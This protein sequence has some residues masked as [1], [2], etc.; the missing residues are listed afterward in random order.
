VTGEPSRGVLTAEEA[1]A[2]ASAL[3]S[4]ERICSS[5]SS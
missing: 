2:A 5:S 4:A 3:R 1:T